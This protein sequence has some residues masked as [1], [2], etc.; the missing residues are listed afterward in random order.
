MITF[1]A[2]IDSLLEEANGE[3]RLVPYMLKL[4]MKDAGIPVYIDPKDISDV[5]VCVTRGRLRC[6]GIFEYEYSDDVL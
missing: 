3:P 4:R 1:Y 6:L 2:S 5:S